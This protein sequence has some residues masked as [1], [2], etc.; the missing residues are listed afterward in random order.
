MSVV[1]QEHQVA[2]QQEVSLKPDKKEQFLKER[3]LTRLTTTFPLA[4]C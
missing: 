4:I 3:R 2:Q 1:S